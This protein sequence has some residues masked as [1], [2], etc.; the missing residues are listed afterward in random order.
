MLRTLLWAVTTVVVAVGSPR[1]LTAQDSDSLPAL[2]A[3][4]GIDTTK[5]QTT[6]S[7]LRTLD[8][9][10]GDGAL[11][12]AEKQVSVHYTLWRTT[13]EKMESS[14]DGGEPFSFTLGTGQVIA[15]WDEGVAGMKVGGIRKLVVPPDLAYGD[16][17]LIFEIEVLGV[18]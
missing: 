1:A 12:E 18:E 3:S 9:K 15:G 6:E 10:V 8:V 13:G 14:R 4:L 16:A 7:G 11:A 2:D 17:T 5:L